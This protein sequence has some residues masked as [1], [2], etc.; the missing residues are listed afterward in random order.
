MEFYYAEFQGKTFTDFEYT[1]TPAGD[2]AFNGAWEIGPD[3]FLLSLSSGV[4]RDYSE[5]KLL[6]NI[7]TGETTDPLEK[8]PLEGIAIQN[9]DFTENLARALIRSHESC[10]VPPRLM[11]LAVPSFFPSSQSL[12]KFHP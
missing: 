11:V 9:I 4:Q 5:Y 1:E 10:P 6:L 12:A 2:Y 8:C 3:T 7:M